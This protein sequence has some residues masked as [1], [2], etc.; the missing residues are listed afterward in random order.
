MPRRSLI[1]VVSVVGGS[2]LAV[3]AGQAD[4]LTAPLRSMDPWPVLFLAGVV[5][6]GVSSVLFLTAIRTIGGTRTGILMLWEPVVGVILAALWL[7][8]ALSPIQGAGGA[9]VL[10]GAVVL[11]VRSDPDLEPVVEAGAGPVV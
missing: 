6:A 1:L 5:A 8:E 10:L 4:G 7:G 9:L 3:I 2:V 11:Q